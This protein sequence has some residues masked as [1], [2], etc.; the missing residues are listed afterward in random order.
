MMFITCVLLAF[1]A[2]RRAC[3]THAHTI[4]FHWRTTKG[5]KQLWL[6]L[7][8]TAF[9]CMFQPT[10]HR[11]RWIKSRQIRKC[12]RIFLR[13]RVMADLISK[14]C[15]RYPPM[16]LISILYGCFIVFYCFKCNMKSFFGIKSEARKMT[17]AMKSF[18]APP[19]SQ[20]LPIHSS[21]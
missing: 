19:P 2:P 8:F 14:S 6:P 12:V 15:T 20:P 4:H 21:V 1:Q 16:E 13:W 11:T 17:V 5:Q 18:T 10:S 3:I 9:Y 7:P